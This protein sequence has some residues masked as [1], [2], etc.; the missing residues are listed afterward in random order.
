M[1]D[2]WKS[3]GEVDLHA[4]KNRGKFLVVGRFVTQYCMFI[5]YSKVWI[6]RVRLTILLVVS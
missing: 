5:T 1:D 2:E 3:R 4:Y 6:N